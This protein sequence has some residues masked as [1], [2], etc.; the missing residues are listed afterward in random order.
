MAAKVTVS[1]R[2]WD[3]L[4]SVVDQATWGPD[5]PPKVRASLPALAKLLSRVR[6][7]LDKAERP[8]AGGL[9][10]QAAEAVLAGADCRKYAPFAGGSAARLV[11]RMRQLAVTEE[12]L[13]TV[14]L[15]LERQPWMRGQWA[16][17]TL[18]GKWEQWLAQATA[19]GAPRPAADVG[20][21]GF[22]EDA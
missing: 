22:E 13:R 7:A 6:A 4:D 11:A 16:L 1:L 10:L 5:C 19:A 14:G 3:A 15:W 20:P 9:S 18:L 8:T 21:A 2:D 17:A 12:Q